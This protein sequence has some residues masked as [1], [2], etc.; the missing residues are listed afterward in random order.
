MAFL[1][2]LSERQRFA[3]NKRDR[4]WRDQVYRLERINAHRVRS[5]RPLVA[6]LE[7]IETRGRRT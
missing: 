1:L 5:G 4:Y 6:S 2:P 3:R 7:E